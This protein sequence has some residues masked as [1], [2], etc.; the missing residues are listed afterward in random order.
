MRA[1][2][3]KITRSQINSMAIEFLRKKHYTSVGSNDISFDFDGRYCGPQGGRMSYNRPD[4]RS[5]ETYM[6]DV[7]N[8]YHEHGRHAPTLTILQ[9]VFA[10]SGVELNRNR[11]SRAVTNLRNRGIVHAS[12]TCTIGL[13]YD[14]GSTKEKINEKES[15][16]STVS[17]E[18]FAYSSMLNK[19]ETIIK[20]IENKN[21]VTLSDIN[22]RK[23]H[24]TMAKHVR[25]L[26]KYLDNS[27]IAA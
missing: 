3:K 27:V 8:F 17:L 6:I 21:P 5:V 24:R 16:Q 12:H 1:I 10:E 11:V 14:H 4:K 2:Y 26:I 18:Y 25:G 9:D 20:S 7:L 15:N 23:N 22:D 19:I 13:W